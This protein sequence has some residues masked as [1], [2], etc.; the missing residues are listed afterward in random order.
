MANSL[1]HR[2]M[3]GEGVREEK[4]WRSPEIILEGAIAYNYLQLRLR[5][6]RLGDRTV[7][8]ADAKKACRI[9]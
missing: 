3:R 4:R 7:P 9:C 2:P 8:E 6:I 1:L 5:S